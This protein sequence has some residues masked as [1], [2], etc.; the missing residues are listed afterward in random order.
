MSEVE[1][2]HFFSVAA[3]MSQ[4]SLHSMC[5]LLKYFSKLFGLCC[6]TYITIRTLCV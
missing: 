1:I 4:W 3:S 5:M 2:V 6:Y